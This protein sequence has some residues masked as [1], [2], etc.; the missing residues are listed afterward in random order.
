MH[1]PENEWHREKTEIIKTQ[2]FVSKYT[3]IHWNVKTH[4]VCKSGMNPT[5]K[6]RYEKAK[7]VIRRAKTVEV[8]QYDCC[9]PM[10]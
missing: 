2:Y 6:Q 3:I 8:G 1:S 5:Y 4:R 9:R 7:E 10:Q